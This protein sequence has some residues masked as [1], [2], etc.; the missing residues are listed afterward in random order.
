[1]LTCIMYVWIGVLYHQWNKLPQ[2][3]AAYQRALSLD[4]SHTSARN[5]YA[6]LL[7]TL[8]KKST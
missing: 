1:M 5:N 7:R 3:Q 6:L 8:N 4:A 2:A